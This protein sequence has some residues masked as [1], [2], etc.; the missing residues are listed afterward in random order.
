MDISRAYGMGRQAAARGGEIAE[1]QFDKLHSA[2]T[3]ESLT[4]AF[5]QGVRDLRAENQI[6]KED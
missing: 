4:T 2:R 5:W 6:N 1:P 3:A